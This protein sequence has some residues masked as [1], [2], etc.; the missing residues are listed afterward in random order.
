VEAA[1]GGVRIL[2]VGAG[3]GYLCAALAHL[4]GPSSTVVGV[5]KA[6]AVARARGTRR[7][8]WPPLALTLL[9]PALLGPPPPRP[10]S[11]P[12]SPNVQVPELAAAAAANVA[13]GNPELA[14][15]VR[16]ISGDALG[17]AL[18]GEQPFSAIHVGA[19]AQDAV[20][21]GLLERLLP[22]GR[23]VLPVGP[24][25]GVQH[26]LTVDRGTDGRL[27]YNRRMAVQ[28]V[29]LTKPGE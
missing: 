24:R 5:E 28:Y 1:G 4:G 25:H 18:A 17:D 2:D 6:R 15:R 9:M 29:P 7:R 16:I 3:S 26:L 12:P 11:P 8:C 10:R 22:G 23:L 14:P 19:A 27:V 13:A 21:P 20:P